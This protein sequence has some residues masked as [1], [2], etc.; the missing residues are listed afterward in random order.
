MIVHGSS[1]KCLAIP[2][3]RSKIVMEVCDA[4]NE[5]HKWSFENYNPGKL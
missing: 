5:R 1:K 2:P 4:T 3:D